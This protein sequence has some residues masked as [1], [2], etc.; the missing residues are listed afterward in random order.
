MRWEM[1]AR[2]RLYYTRSV[3][4]NGRVRRQYVGRGEAAL[5]AA[6]QDARERAE[7]RARAAAWAHE[8]ADL[9]SSDASIREL[10]E[11]A[12]LVMA[13]VLMSSG[14]HRHNR[15]EWSLRRGQ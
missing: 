14:Y 3:R 13:G 11:I 15:G 1:R 6:E 5:L 9:E 2:G 12:E 7:R 8:R 10:D 4:I